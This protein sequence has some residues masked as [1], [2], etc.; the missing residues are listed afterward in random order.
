MLI[1]LINMMRHRRVQ[2]A[3]M[4]FLL[5]SQKKHRTWIMLKQLLLLLLRMAAV[6]AVVLMVAQPRLQNQL[7]NLLGG[8]R[9]HHIVLLDDSF[10]MS[11]RWADTDAFSEAK[12][13]VRTHRRQRRPARSPPVVHAVAVFARGHGQRARGTRLAQA[14]GGQ[15]SSATNWRPCWPR[16]KS[17]RPAAGPLPALQ[18]VGQLLGRQRRRAANL[19]P[20]LRFP[21]PAMERA[22]RA[23]QGAAGNSARR[24]RRS[25]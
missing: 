20:D 5:V 13:V 22:G 14:A 23:A 21:R 18:A 12:K 16:S 24:G 11:D 3:A 7:G 15:P 6:A 19:L 9:T 4:E 2:W 17:R 10:S 1:H 8:T 25:T